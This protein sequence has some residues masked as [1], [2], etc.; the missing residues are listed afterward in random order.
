MGPVPSFRILLSLGAVVL[1]TLLLGTSPALA[2]AALVETDPAGGAT[3]ERLPEVATATFSEPVGS[4]AYLVVTAPDGTD[5]S[6]GVAEVVDNTVSVPLEDVGIRGDYR[7]SYRVVS[8]DGHPIQGEI[9]FEVTSGDTV[10]AADTTP[11]AS[12][13]SFVHR[14][15]EHLLWGIAI[16]V[17]ALALIFWPMLRRRG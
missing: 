17:V 14:H 9:G 7:M 8:A 11:A 13:E 2:H 3:L 16:G 1:A 15:T 12:Q 6:A 10:D 4:S 5:A